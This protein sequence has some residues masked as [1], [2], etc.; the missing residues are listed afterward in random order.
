MAGFWSL[1]DEILS[2]IITLLVTSADG[3]TDL[4]RLS[5]TC[6][7]FLALSRMSKVL[8]VVNF[9]NISIDDYEDHRH[10]KGLLC[11]CARAGN[12]AAESM[13]GKALLHNDAF[14]WRVILE[15]DRPRLAR[16]PQAS[17]L[18]CHQK[19]V[20][21][22]ICDAS[23][24]DIA[25]MRIPLFSYMISILGYDVAWLS[26]ILLAVSNMCCYYLEELE[27]VVSFE[28]MPPLR[29]IDMALAWLTPPSGEAHRAEV[30]EIYDKMVP[31][32][33]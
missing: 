18:L 22:F 3:A 20:R 25:P 1:N 11:L 21:R 31:G 14:F 13:L 32:L 16:V 17:G 26:G 7:K 4:A 5:A 27:D 23:D 9:E 12:P 30:L 6:R 15:H 24:T 19:L 10:R 2:L 28:Q 33:E 8:K 29:G